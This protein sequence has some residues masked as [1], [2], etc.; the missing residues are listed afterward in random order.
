VATF[1]QLADVDRLL[2]FHHD[3]MH[4]DEQLESMLARVRDLRADGDVE[5]TD[6][7]GEGLRIELSS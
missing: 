2:M 7:A 3:P 5:R 1:A 6:L 4:S